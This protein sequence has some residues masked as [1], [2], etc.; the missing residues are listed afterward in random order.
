MKKMIGALMS[1]TLGLS[2]PAMADPKIDNWHTYHSMGCMMLGE[3]TEGVDK[4]DGPTAFG[5]EFSVFSEELDSIFM[6]LDLI[7]VEAYLADAKY[8]KHNTRGL[9][10]VTRNTFFLNK[11]YLDQPE[12]IVGVI[13][14]EGWH[15]A[16]DC[17]AG[18]L[19]NTF[20]AVILQDGVVPDWVSATALKTYKEK[21]APY[22]A[23]AM[24]AA[25]HHGQTATALEA[26]ASATP[27]WETYE[28]TPMT[29]EWLNKNGFIR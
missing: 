18:T 15:I 13:R 25:F 20:T 4:I 28:P 29:R 3:C 14:H 8:F 2:G 5:E 12:V 6:S 7:G 19:D 23:E 11:K 1:L 22:E 21:A 24:Y 27:M 17:M 26:C 9:Y 10:D 16:Q